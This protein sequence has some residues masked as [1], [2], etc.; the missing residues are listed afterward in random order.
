V[1]GLPR[2]PSASCTDPHIRTFVQNLPN[3]Q[4]HTGL[5][6]AFPG[7]PRKR[8]DKPNPMELDHAGALTA[9]PGLHFFLRRRLHMAIRP[10]KESPVALQI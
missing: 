9:L 5:H 4:N 1:C 3:L 2:Y 7:K 8:N 6:F 10:G